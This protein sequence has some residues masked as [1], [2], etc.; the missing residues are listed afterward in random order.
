MNDEVRYCFAKFLVTFYS[1]DHQSE[2]RHCWVCFLI[3]ILNYLSQYAIVDDENNQ[4]Y[5]DD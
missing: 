1:F 2:V 4:N 3:V 5:I